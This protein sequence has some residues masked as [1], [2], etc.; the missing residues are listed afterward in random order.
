MD[1]PVCD[2][3]IQ[4]NN[5]NNSNYTGGFF[6]SATKVRHFTARAADTSILQD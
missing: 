3:N 4:M 6:I 1:S 5:S 2:S